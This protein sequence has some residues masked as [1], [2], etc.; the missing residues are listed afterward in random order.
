MDLILLG[1][2]FLQPDTTY[3][4][5]G[6]VKDEGELQ[7]VYF[8]WIK[9]GLLTLPRVPGAFSTVT[10]GIVEQVTGYD[11]KETPYKIIFEGMDKHPF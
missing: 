7:N 1:G 3:I 8:D 10:T 5:A 9:F 4:L 11:C 6:M 2:S